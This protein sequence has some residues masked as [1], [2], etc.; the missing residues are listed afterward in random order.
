MPDRLTPEEH[1]A[2]LAI[3]TL[4]IIPPKRLRLLAKLVE[5]VLPILAETDG[6][7]VD[8]SI[9]RDLRRMADLSEQVLGDADG[10]GQI[11]N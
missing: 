9:E 3:E 7:T 4:K 8:D 10:K 2:K 5:F 1:R 11:L 6:V